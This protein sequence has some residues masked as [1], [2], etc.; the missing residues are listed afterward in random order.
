MKI[1][2]DER[3]KGKSVAIFGDSKYSIQSITQ[4][5]IG[6]KKLGWKKKTGEIKNLELIKEMFALHQSIKDDVH[7]LHVHGSAGYGRGI[8][9]PLS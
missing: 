7:V 5:A 8:F 4:W 9:Y 3:G 6:W 1:A 2:R